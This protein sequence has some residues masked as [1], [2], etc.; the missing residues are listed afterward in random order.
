MDHETY[1]L[2]LTEANLHRDRMPLQYRLS[3]SA[4]K[5]YE[6]NTLSPSEWHRLVMRMRTPHYSS[7]ERSAG[8]IQESNRLFKK[9]HQ[10][11]YNLNNLGENKCDDETCKYDMLCRLLTAHSHN[12]TLCEHFLL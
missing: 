3:Y 11:F 1:Y 8:A 6:M 9:L 5:A 2:N 12:M 7:D 4:R 10:Y